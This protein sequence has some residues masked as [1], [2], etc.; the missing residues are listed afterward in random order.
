MATIRKINSRAVSTNETGFGTNSAYSG[1][2]FYNKDGTANVQVDGVGF[3]KKLSLYKA[4]LNMSGSALF[5][6]ILLFYFGINL[7][8]AGIYLALGPDNLGGGDSGGADGLN[9]F[10]EAFFFSAQ[11][12]S[13]VG[14]GHIYPRG[15]PTNI[16][17]GIESLLGLLAFA[18]ATAIIYGK[19]TQ[20]RAFIHFSR[21][22]LIAPYNN[23]RAIMFRMAPYKHNHLTDAEVK[24]TLAMKLQEDGKV[25]NKFFTLPL[26]ISKVNAL[27]ISWTI[28]HAIDEQSPFY[29]LTTEDLRTGNAELLVFLKAFDESFS[30][31]VIARSSYTA[32]EFVE[33]AKF[34]L[35]Y[36]PS[37]NKQ[38]T[39]LDM[40][41]LDAFDRAELPD[42][43]STRKN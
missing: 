24:V 7:S 9:K 21:N 25:A 41:K 16:F 26:E 33:G 4:L 43:E 42:E 12:V 40:N 37:E 14:Y 38:T 30:N 28:V 1:G 34:Q 19:F 36:H 5:S 29:N 27:T 17:A 2:R 31:S 6:I 15:L 3:F 23:G 11:T 35:M 39:V 13:T 10:W 18:F 32:D 8:F 22:A 20:P